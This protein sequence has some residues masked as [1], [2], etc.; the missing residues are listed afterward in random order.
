MDFLRYRHGCVHLCRKWGKAMKQKII[1][2]MLEGIYILIWL[3]VIGSIL[4]AAFPLFNT[5]SLYV[6]VQAQQP[7]CFVELHKERETALYQGVAK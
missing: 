2:F 4:Y 3:A 7:T 6:M 1:D 5:N